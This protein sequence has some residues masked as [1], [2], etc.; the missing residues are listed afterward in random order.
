MSTTFR[1]LT[2]VT[3][4]GCGAMSGVFF[5][6]STFVMAGLRRLPASQG[7]AAMQSINVAAPRSALMALLFG[8]A[9]LCAVMAVRAFATWG[10]RSAALLVVGAVLYLVGAVALTGGYHIPRNDALGELDPNAP[11]T[12]AEWA[13]YATDWTRWNH[14][15]TGASMAASAAFMA[16]L[17]A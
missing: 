16:A 7:T 5:S 17:I 14:V 10:D 6:F 8:T 1:V 4:L 3:A 2:V 9:G 15:R 12:A 11:G 13:R